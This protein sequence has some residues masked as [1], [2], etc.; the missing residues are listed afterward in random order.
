MLSAARNETDTEF[1]AWL[2]NALKRQ[3]RSRLPSEEEELSRPR[4]DDPEVRRR[5][6]EIIN[7]VAEKP[8]LKQKRR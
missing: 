2:R 6:A 4:Y 7:R 3:Q 5:I 1:R 8:G